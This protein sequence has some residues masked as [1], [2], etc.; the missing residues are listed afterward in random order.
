[1]RVSLRWPRWLLIFRPTSSGSFPLKGQHIVVLLPISSCH[2]VWF[3]S[4][5]TADTSSEEWRQSRMCGRCLWR[6]VYITILLLEVIKA[7]ET[8]ILARSTMYS[9]D[10]VMSRW[11]VQ[12]NQ[13][14]LICFNFH[15]SGT[16]RYFSRVAKPQMGIDVTFVDATDLENLKS[17][18]KPNTK[19][20]LGLAF[21]NF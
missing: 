14:W 11:S 5:R 2:R 13:L 10:P 20:R 18:I 7:S 1:M 19:V 4:H 8:L 3:G 6:L 15:S 12:W 17:A 9:F 21:R 16:N